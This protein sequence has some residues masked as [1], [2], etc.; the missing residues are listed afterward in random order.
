MYTRLRKIISVI[1]IMVC[2]LTMFG[3]MA[4]AKEK[5]TNAAYEMI[6]KKVDKTNEFIFKSVDKAILQA[7]KAQKHNKGNDLDECID[8]IIEDLIEKTEEKVDELIDAA[9]D[10]GIEITKT[11]IEVVIGGRVVLV[12]PCYAH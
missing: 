7:D 9:A 5:P 8:E 12:D 10:V 4:Y 1:L 6:L 11:Y 2:L 3:P